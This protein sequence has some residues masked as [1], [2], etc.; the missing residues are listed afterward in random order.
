M[1]RP[2]KA[3]RRSHTDRIVANRRRRLRRE[4]PNWMS[5]PY[6]TSYGRLATMDPWDCGNPR[7]GICHTPDPGQ[8]SRQRREW[9]ADWDL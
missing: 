3:R 6:R 1:A 8:R 5:A 2:S 4:D 7:C 9:R